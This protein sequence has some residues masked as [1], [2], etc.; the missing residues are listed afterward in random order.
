MTIFNNFFCF[1]KMNPYIEIVQ[2]LLPAKFNT[3]IS[4]TKSAYEI[5]QTAS[6]KFQP[7]IKSIMSA[8]NY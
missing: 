6:N 8:T 4:I 7:E 1:Y 3:V 2:L 5:I